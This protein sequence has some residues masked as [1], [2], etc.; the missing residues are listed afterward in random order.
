MALGVN[1]G[2]YVMLAADTRTIFYSWDGIVGNYMDDSVKIQR[3]TMGLITGAGSKG[4]LDFVK[5]RL[6]RE[7][8]TH[9]NQILSIIDEERS[10][11]RSSFWRKPEKDIKMTGWVFSYL[12]AVENGGPAL[13]FGIVHPTFGEVL[14]L[15]EDCCPA[16]ISPFEATEEDA[17]D[18]VDY[19]K[20]RI[21]TVPRFCDAY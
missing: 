15:Y 20:K 7:K 6:G 16:V 8:I 10:R 13:R 1:F 11:Y 17:N 14:G 2:A 5:D 3:T 21:K 18:I 4:L 19:L 12:T 9:T